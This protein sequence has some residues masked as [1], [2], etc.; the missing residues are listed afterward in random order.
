MST[1]RYIV[2][3][4]RS[5]SRCVATGSCSRPRLDGH[6]H[7]HSKPPDE[8][9]TPKPSGKPQT[10]WPPRKVRALPR[11]RPW[12]DRA[13]SLLHPSPSPLRPT[14]LQAGAGSQSALKLKWHARR[15]ARLLL[16]DASFRPGGKPPGL[17]PALSM[18]HPE[19]QH[20]IPRH[21]ASPSSPSKPALLGADAWRTRP[22]A[23]TI[24][25]PPI[26]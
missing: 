15:V 17:F 13:V 11:R 10:L 18:G 22:I 21:C 9:M 20:G 3:M 23:Q 16:M 6:G 25:P 7:G 8:P 19:R 5:R 26:E 24:A 12:L 2:P 1:P 14:Q 4:S